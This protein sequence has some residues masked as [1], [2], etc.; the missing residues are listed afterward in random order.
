MS[1]MRKKQIIEKER[2]LFTNKALAALILPLIVEQ[3]LAVLVGMADSVMVAS[4]GG[5]AVSGVSLVDNIMVLF[6]NLFAALATGYSRTV[7]RA[8]KRKTCVP[9]GNTACMV[10]YDPGS[11]DHGGYILR[12]MVCPACGIRAD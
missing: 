2:L 7:S 4:V 11:G 10:H 3:F 12:E 5:A 1:G 6:T 8:E 9:R